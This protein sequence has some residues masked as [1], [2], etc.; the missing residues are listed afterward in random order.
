MP[1]ALARQEPAVKELLGI[2]DGH[3]LAA[4]LE[5]LE[6]EPLA[7]DAWARAEAR[8]DLEPLAED[9]KKLVALEGVGSKIA[10]KIIEFVSTGKIAEHEELAA[11]VPPGLLAMLAIPGLG[12]KTVRAIWQDKGVTDVAG[13]KR[14]VEPAIQP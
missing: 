4:L 8:L 9:K 12:P 6:P 7:T 10:D 3:A 13:L 14:M 5:E 1:T 11:R 2:P